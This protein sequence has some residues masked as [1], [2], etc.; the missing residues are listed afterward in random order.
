MMNYKGNID[1]DINQ[2]IKQKLVN[3]EILA[4]VSDMV[5]HLFDYEGRKMALWDE[6]E[7]LY[8]SVCPECG[9]HVPES[10]QDQLEF[11]EDEAKLFG[12]NAWKC[13]YCGHVQEIEPDTE[14][15]E[16]YEYWIVTPWFGKKLRNIGEPVFERWGGWIWGRCCT[17]QSIS[18]DYSISEIA[19][20]MEI[21]DGMANCK[22]WKE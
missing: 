14:M 12:D 16:I 2:R 10:E 7:N 11:S 19:Y 15:Q 4:C 9:A 3:R 8:I 1:S 5:E 20:G 18:L 22:S 21:L 13:P 17:G 6:W